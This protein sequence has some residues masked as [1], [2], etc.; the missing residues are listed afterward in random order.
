MAPLRIGIIGCGRI[1]P[2]H[3]HGY[4]LALEGGHIDVR[5]S[6]LAARRLDDARMFAKRGE[7]PPPRPPVSRNPGDPLSAPHLYVSDLHP[8]TVPRVTDD[9]RSLIHDDA[10]D[11]VDIT[12]TVSTHHEMA[13]AALEAGKHVMMQKPIAVSVRAAKAMVAAA[14]ANGRVLA[15]MENVRYAKGVRAMKWAI[16]SGLIGELQMTAGLSIGTADWSPDLIVADTPWRHHQLEAGGGA[17]IDIGV[18]LFHQHRYVCGEI[19]T[20]SALTRTF[21][22]VRRRRPDSPQAATDPTTPADVDDAYFAHFEF[23]NGAI[24]Q[25]TFTWA[26]H[27]ES[28]HLPGGNLIYVSKGCIKG[29]QVHLDDGRSLNLV[30]HFTAHAPRSVQDRWFPGG[31]TDAFALAYIDFAGAIREGRETDASG[32]EGL[33]DLA[34]AFAILE[35]GHAKAPVRV[36]DVVSG[37]VDAYQRPIDRHYKLV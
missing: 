28:A 19:E 33:W 10:L 35:S 15:V 6:A 34:C 31:I 9:W 7:G 36:A 5:I 23:K 16:E 25:S 37:R 26:G 3:L 18:H 14:K 22:P 17:A 4:R 13:I 20:V 21:E 30:E 24:G 32:E 11:A 1:L 27:G 12:T 2:A 8:D 29:G